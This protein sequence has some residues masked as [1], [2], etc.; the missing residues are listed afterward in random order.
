M[1]HFEL[2][3]PF[4]E[5]TFTS[6]SPL[7]W[8]LPGKETQIRSQLDWDLTAY[9]TVSPAAADLFHIATAAY[10]A[11]LLTGR[12]LTFG[13]QIHLAVHVYDPDLWRGEAGQTIVDLLAW[14]SGDEW[15]L[16]P[17][18]LGK[19]SKSTEEA[20]HPPLGNCADTMLLSGG[21]DSFCGAVDHL[22]T[23]KTRLHIGHRDS[24]TSVKHA[25]RMTNTW[26][27]EQQPEF[28]WLRHEVRASSRKREN[29]TRTRSFLFMAMA[30]AAAEGAGAHEVIV[31][32]NGY[33][34]LNL[35]LVASR[36]GALSTKSTHP[37]TFHLVST[38]VAQ[39]SIDVNVGNPYLGMTKGELLKQAAAG[40]PDGFLAATKDTLSC[41][42][43]DSGRVRKADGGNPNINCGLCYACLT[44]RGSY[45]GAGIT[46]PTDYLVNR[47]KGPARKAFY[48]RRHDDLWALELA[49]KR[50][51]TEDDLIASAS[52]PD[53]YDLGQALD[54]VNRGRSEIF[55]VPR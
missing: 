53:D 54:I 5:R 8:P 44:R 15:T 51:I 33:T 41:A 47:L 6:A 23:A 36:G 20:L 29:T 18:P 25:Q 35:P 22:A 9:G 16:T 30:I 50:T 24:A 34:S 45:V 13:R 42:K 26:F 27:T 48:R 10:I 12:P 3:A 38:L 31:P 39:A 19:Y 43:L 21:L 11:D 4:E 32:E 7:W 37:W 52:W 49:E 1:R 17:V 40:A 28:T 55:S 2:L 46:D 14:V